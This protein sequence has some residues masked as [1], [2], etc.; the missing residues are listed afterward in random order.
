MTVLVRGRSNWIRLGNS[1]RYLS[2]KSEILAITLLA[3]AFRVWDLYQ[4][5][6]FRRDECWEGTL[7]VEIY[8]G[9][10][11]LTN[12]VDYLSPLF[13]YLVALGFV[14]FRVNFMVPRAIV[15]IVGV[16]TVVL[17]YLFARDL[18]GHR[19]GLLAGFLLAIAPSHIIV[20]SHV[21]WSA[22]LSP[23]FVTLGAY[24]LYRASKQ[25]T[26]YY[27]A[28][29]VFGLAIQTHPVT[30]IAVVGALVYLLWVRPANFMGKT[31]M[32]TVLSFCF[33]YIN[34]IYVIVSSN[35]QPLFSGASQRQ[36]VALASTLIQYCDRFFLHLLVFAKFLS[37]I[38][39]YS[40]TTMLQK[41]YFYIYPI[42]LIAGIV[43]CVYKR[44]QRD[45]LLLSFLSAFFLI[46]PMFIV[47]NPRY[48]FP[49]PHGPHYYAFI[50]PLC[51]VVIAK[52]VSTII[53]F[54]LRKPHRLNFKLRP[55]L[56]ALMLLV[57]LVYPVWA[58]NDVLSEFHKTNET[59]KPFIEATEYI[60]NHKAPKTI[61]LLDK[62]V[63]FGK[64]LK[65]F[66]QFASGETVE[67]LLWDAD[68]KALIA[69]E[70]A[71]KGNRL[72]FV[73]APAS[74]IEE[75]VPNLFSMLHP[76]I[77]PAAIAFSDDNEPFYEIYQVDL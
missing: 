68:Y 14:F 31:M 56:V 19:T 50:V 75:T 63:P 3:L 6:M 20:S 21:G 74:A 16:L 29:F 12:I 42:L 35:F 39:A 65:A 44:E 30:L 45:K 36:Y 28:A 34:M 7:G 5:P 27:L 23:Y 54:I 13:N 9:K 70:H 47:V 18:F 77:K 73:Y 22:N 53:D 11:A 15:A 17:I 46:V 59:N 41:W 58:L 61:V 1:R 4:I 66:I 32:K 8:L 60:L 57:V 43:L 67:A 76:N 51:F 33:G 2:F 37:A 55:L 49:N 52:I 38:K 10:K 64:Q 71:H 72:F 48:S 26:F 69:W 40:L 62:Y 24:L 25:A